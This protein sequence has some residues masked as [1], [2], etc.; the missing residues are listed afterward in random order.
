MS[1]CDIMSL[2]TPINFQH[3]QLDWVICSPLVTTKESLDCTFT[4]FAFLYPIGGRQGPDQ[5]SF[6]TIYGHSLFSPVTYGVIHQWFYQWPNLWF[7]SILFNSL[8]PSGAIWCQK[9]IQMK[10]C[11][12]IAANHYLNQCWLIINEA[13]WQSPEGSSI[14]V[15]QTVTH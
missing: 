10:A 13:Q 7:L 1:S 15:T 5:C 8:W 12:L 4:L 3:F 9:Q 11:C 6:V 14:R 2:L